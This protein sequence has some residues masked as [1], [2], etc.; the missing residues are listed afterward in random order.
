MIN[1]LNYIN[2]TQLKN[3]QM[4]YQFFKGKGWTSEAITGMLGNIHAESGTIA[5]LDERSGGGGYGLVQWTPKS[6]L[7]DWA[8]ALDLDHATLLTQC[9]R[10]QWELEN[11]HQF[12]A[13]TTFPYT[14]KEFSKSTKNPSYLAMVFMYNYE[15]P[16]DLDQ[17]HRAQYATS[18]F[19]ILVTRG[20]NIAA[21]PIPDPL[22]SS[23]TVI[24][25]DTLS[26]I[27]K[28]FGTTVEKLQALNAIKNPDKISV[29][30]I[31]KL[32]AETKAD[33]TVEPKTTTTSPTPT[34]YT[35]KKGDTLS[36]IAKKFNTSVDVLKVLNNLNYA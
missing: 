15:R 1:L 31:L 20:N 13:T 5:D 27:A 11:A 6:K 17:P 34:T 10:I 22:V 12:Y 21:N 35:V 30:Q 16:Y 8:R 26:A 25:G 2:D 33:T 28:R 19:D 4:I 32:P 14:F 23:Y 24:A 29:G 18:W 3:A 36:A 9:K 7:V